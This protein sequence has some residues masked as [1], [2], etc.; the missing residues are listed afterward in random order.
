VVE[1]MISSLDGASAG[2]CF[3]RA[4]TLR[5]PLSRRRVHLSATPAATP[6]RGVKRPEDPST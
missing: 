4:K 3:T 1:M 2:T 6:R 5:G